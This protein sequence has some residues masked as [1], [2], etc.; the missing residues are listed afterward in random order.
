VVV[1]LDHR[2]TA[3]DATKYNV[4]GTSKLGIGNTEP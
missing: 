1:E 2:R 4:G 3:T